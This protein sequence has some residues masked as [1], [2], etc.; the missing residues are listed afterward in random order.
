MELRYLGRSGIR[1]SALTLGAM[2]FGS[3]GNADREDCIRIIH[4]ALDAGINV[5]DTADVYSAGESEQIVGAA[6]LGRRDDVVLASKFGLPRGEDPTLGAAPR[7]WIRQAVEASLRRLGSHRLGL[8]RLPR[9]YD[10]PGPGETLSA[11]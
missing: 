11:L 6:I 9:P 10:F 3:M 4:R 8:Y 7:R 5:I 2:S 1:V